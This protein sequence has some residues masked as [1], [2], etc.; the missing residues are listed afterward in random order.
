M[1]DTVEWNL[2]PAPF[3]ERAQGQERKFCA[4]GWS[5]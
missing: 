3:F 4:A 2:V 5:A 1:A